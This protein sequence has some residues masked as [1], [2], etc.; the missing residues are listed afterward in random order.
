[1]IIGGYTRNSPSSRYLSDVELIKFSNKNDECNRLDLD[2]RVCCHA[3]VASSKGVL[4]CG[5]STGN[6]PLSKCIIQASHRQT[7]FP[8]MVN[9]R[10]SFGMMNIEGTIYAIG[11]VELGYGILYRCYERSTM[12]TINIEAGRKWK[13]EL[14]PFNVFSHCV[15][16][17]H[18]TLIV[19]GGYDDHG[20][21]VS[22]QLRLC[23]EQKLHQNKELIVKEKI[24]CV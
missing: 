6:K 17:I 11:G 3:S 24:C 12:E 4:T 13:K 16:A 5:G 23:A 15:V 21:E 19:I 2:H 18:T 1:M 14:V 7:S 22:K 20:H 9:N 10:S 8:S